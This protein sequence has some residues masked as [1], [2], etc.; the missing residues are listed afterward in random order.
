M[1]SEGGLDFPL[2]KQIDREFVDFFPQLLGGG[3]VIG[4]EI[5]DGY[6]AREAIVIRVNFVTSLADIVGF[7]EFLG[8]EFGVFTRALKRAC[9]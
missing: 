7:G 2:F 8:E 3:V 9:F 5:A 1:G 4:F 6:V